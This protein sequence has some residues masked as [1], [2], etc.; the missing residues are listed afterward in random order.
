ME[1]LP[2]VLEYSAQGFN[3]SQVLLLLGL[4]LQGK[5]NP[6]LIS[7]VQSLGGGIG[8][9]GLNCGALTGGACLLG[10]FAGRNESAIEED[11]RLQLM[12]IDLVDWF[13]EQIV[14][15]YGGV[16]CADILEGNR[17]NYTLRCVEIIE[18][19]FQKCKE[20]LVDYG[21]NIDGCDE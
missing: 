8:F 13:K 7:A 9:S 2:K 1:K 14:Q 21:Y 19:V 16:D 6:E 18:V 4:E 3:C 12:L 10:L 17:A 20:L 5:E 15:K 11:E